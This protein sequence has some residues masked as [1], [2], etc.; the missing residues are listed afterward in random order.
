[1]IRFNNL[2]QQ[3]EHITM[4][5]EK[6]YTNGEITVVWKADACVHSGNCVRG[7]P[8]AFKPN[9]SPWIHMDGASTEELKAQVDKCPSGALSCYMNDASDGSGKE[10][11]P[12]P[13]SCKL[14]LV[15][16][17]PLI[18]YGP[19]E[20]TGKHGVELK[21]GPKTFLCRCGASSKKPYCDGAH[22]KFDFE[23]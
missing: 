11:T 4:S 19:I 1:V 20:I 17:G 9:D 21:S 7:L 16:N 22:K 14:E 13:K 15:N 23:G 12:V 6:E 5:K 2:I 8:K 18:I 3:T 10:Q